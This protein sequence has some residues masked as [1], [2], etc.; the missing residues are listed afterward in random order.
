[1]AS[2][3]SCSTVIAFFRFGAGLGLAARG[4]FVEGAFVVLLVFLE[5]SFWEGVEMGAFPASFPGLFDDTGTFPPFFIFSFLAG[6]PARRDG[7]AML[8]RPNEREQIRQGV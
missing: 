6:M 1:M 3:R 8:A 5:A 2:C 4:S 7:P